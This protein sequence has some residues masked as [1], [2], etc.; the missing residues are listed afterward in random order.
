MTRKAM[1]ACSCNELLFR[2]IVAAVWWSHAQG[3]SRVAIQSAPADV[4]WLGMNRSAMRDAS[5]P[6]NCKLLSRCDLP[7]DVP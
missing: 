3:L 5:S 7:L 1:S 6:S 4:R 2:Q